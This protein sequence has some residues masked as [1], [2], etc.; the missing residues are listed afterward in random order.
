M[1]TQNR[2]S[3]GQ[4]ARKYTYST[5]AEFETAL[6]EQ[7]AAYNELQQEYTRCYNAL[8]CIRRWLFNRRKE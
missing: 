3:N 4:F 8:G 1:A 2:Q 6:N 5:L 7:K